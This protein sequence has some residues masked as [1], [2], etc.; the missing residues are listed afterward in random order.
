MTRLSKS[1]DLAEFCCNDRAGTPVPAHLVPN[2]IDLAVGVL[3]PIRD[4]WTGPI[5]VVSGYRTQAWNTAVGGVAGSAHLTAEAADIRPVHLADVDR[6]LYL[7]LSTYA[8]GLLP[9]LGGIGSYPR[10]V[11][12]DIRRLALGRLRRWTGTGTGSEPE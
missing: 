11:H 1:F 9:L 7:I 10:W 4:E 12:V 2:V 8:R 3:Q 6:L 5:L